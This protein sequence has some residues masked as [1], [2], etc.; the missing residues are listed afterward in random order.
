M[1]TAELVSSVLSTA[2][3]FDG[4]N[5]LPL[6]LRNRYSYDVGAA[7]LDTGNPSLHADI[8]SMR[9][10]G[11]GAQFWSV[12][13]PSDMPPAEAVV[14]TLEQVDC[15]YRLIDTFSQDLQ[16]AVKAQDVQQAVDAGRIASLLGMEGG[17][18]IDSSLGTLRMMR[19]LG[20]RYMTLTHNDNTPWAASATGEPVDYGLTAF[21]VR[22]VKE[23][24]RIGMMVDLSHVHARTMHHALDV[25]TYPVIFSHSSC[26]SVTAH[27]RNVPDDVLTRLADNGGV[28]MLTFVPWFIN[29]GAAAHRED[30][31]RRRR[32]LGLPARTH[33][34]IVAGGPKHAAAET[35][36]KAWLHDNPEPRATID[37]VVAHIEYAREV[38]GIDHI[39][40][41]SD[42]DGLDTGPV[43]LE[44]TTDYPRLLESLVAKGWGRRDLEKLTSKNIM[45]VLNDCDR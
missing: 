4:H 2:P 28:Q 38:V 3:V 5:D 10:G 33:P 26:Y 15:V 17:H 1:R 7:K 34:S 37:D 39:G 16:L 20:V 24:N 23:M 35:E 42:F 6:Q 13:V 14:A 29:V 25:S 11:V 18:S 44:R 8:P 45:R 22:V 19:R 43:G 36:F 27:P 40:L 32:E 21:G 9:R 31:V 12:Y 41:G 30:L